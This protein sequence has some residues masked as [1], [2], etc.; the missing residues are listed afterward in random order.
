[1]VAVDG[2]ERI[3][4]E[5]GSHGRV[6][7]LVARPRSAR[8]G[9]VLAHGA[10]AGMDH[11]FMRAAAEGLAQRGIA[12]L[13]YQFPYMQRGSKRP[14]SPPVAQAAVRAA[15]AEASRIFDGLPLS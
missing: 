12:T 2:L 11:P 3:G 10:G 13:R 1:M 14:D 4:F 8:A 9:Y 7:G 5:A 6:D 15:V